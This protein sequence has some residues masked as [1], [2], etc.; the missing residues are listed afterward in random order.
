MCCTT[1]GCRAL[2]FCGHGACRGT[3][4]EVCWALWPVKPQKIPRNNSLKDKDLGAAET[5]ISHN[6]L[7]AC[8]AF[9]KQIFL[10]L[11]CVWGQWLT[12]LNGLVYLD[13]SLTLVLDRNVYLSVIDIKPDMNPFTDIWSVSWTY[14]RW[15][16]LLFITTWWYPL[17]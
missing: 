17:K 5:L 13:S 6:K 10:L 15:H 14:Q 1:K 8:V 3:S 12:P 16:L 7:S 11:A 2:L 4:R 9:N